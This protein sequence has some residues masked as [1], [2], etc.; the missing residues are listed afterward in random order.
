MAFGCCVGKK[1]NNVELEEEE[2]GEWQSDEGTLEKE[3]ECERRGENLD[4]KERDVITKAFADAVA[5]YGGSG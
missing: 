5:K 4:Q 2:E 3:L 1:K